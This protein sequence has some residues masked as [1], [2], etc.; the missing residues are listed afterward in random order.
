MDKCLLPAIQDVL[1]P[2]E[3]Q[4]WDFSYML[5]QAKSNAVGLEGVQY[6][7]ERESLRQ[8]MLFDLDS[9]DIGAVWNNCNYRLRGLIREDGKL[10]A[11]KGFQ[12]FI[13]S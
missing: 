6:K 3:G 10:T 13:N 1:T 7:S 12:F 9:K 4:S 8:Y 11:F 2:N 5:C